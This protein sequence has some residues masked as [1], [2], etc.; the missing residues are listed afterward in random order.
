MS[1]ESMLPSLF[2]TPVLKDTS[3]QHLPFKF[4]GGFGLDTQAIGVIMS[5]QAVYSMLVN[6]FVFPAVARRFGVLRI[7]RFACISWPLLYLIT[8]YTVLLPEFLA[9][10]SIYAISFC[11][12]TLHILAYPTN[13][14][15]IANSVPSLLV[16][17]TIN[18][19]AASA[20]SLARAFGPTLAGMLYST[21]LRSGYI[22]LLWW[23]LAG[24][25]S[26]GF[27]LSLCLQERESVRVDL[28]VRTEE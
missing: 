8:P 10:P 25:A 13:A 27:F 20:A 19:V 22:S 5:V 17:G 16:L 21:G 14:I 3:N 23:V 9:V 24:V 6:L 26:L 28:V 1:N 15:L 7:F 11:R 12:C 2:S 4:I 18:G